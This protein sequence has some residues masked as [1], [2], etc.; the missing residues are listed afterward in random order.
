[1]L[2]CDWSVVGHTDELWPNGWTD[3]DGFGIGSTRVMLEGGLG[4][5]TNTPPNLTPK[6]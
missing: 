3:R 5:T 6:I 4:S 1:M 2:L